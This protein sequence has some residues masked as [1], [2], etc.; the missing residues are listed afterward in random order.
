MGPYFFTQKLKNM[1]DFKV[2]DQGHRYLART[3]L[4]QEV[5]ID[6]IQ[7][8]PVSEGSTE[9]KLVN[10]GLTNEVLLEILENR[11][12]YLYDKLPSDETKEAIFN[13]QKALSLLQKRTLR[14]IN[15]GTEG[16]NG[17]N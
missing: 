8:V 15:A 14:R 3:Y 7:K 11:L 9:L 12:L 4:N 5:E 2:V 6:F 13:V 10:D 1:K 17:G 16:T